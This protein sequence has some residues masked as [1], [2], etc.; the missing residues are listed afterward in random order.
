MQ[1]GYQD[2][3][4]RRDELADFVGVTPRQRSPRR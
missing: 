4:K 1:L 2:A 3:M